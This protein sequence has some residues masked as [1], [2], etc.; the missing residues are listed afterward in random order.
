[1]VK[2]S[3]R[4]GTFFSL[5][6]A[7]QISFII[8]FFFSIFFTYPPRNIYTNHTWLYINRGLPVK[9][10]GVSLQGKEVPFPI[11][12]APLNR[13]KIEVENWVKIIDLSVFL[14]FFLIVSVLFYIPLQY[15]LV[16]TVRLRWVRNVMICAAILL[17]LICLYLYYFWF[18]R[19]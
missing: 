4:K 10:A 2:K 8:V 15:L 18:P 11:V 16:R 12:I 5:L 6:F 17:S 13:Q 9:W 3:T 19:V 14:P 1:M 7:A